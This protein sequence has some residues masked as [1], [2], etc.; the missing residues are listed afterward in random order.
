MRREAPGLVADGAGPPRVAAELR[1]RG[2]RRRPVSPVGG[3]A[4]PGHRPVT[5]PLATP[6]RAG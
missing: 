2:R 4:R 1:A 3:A 5:A 6:A